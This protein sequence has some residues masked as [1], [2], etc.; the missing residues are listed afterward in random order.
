MRQLKLTINHVL[1][2]DGKETTLEDNPIAGLI[3]TLPI[4]DYV[5]AHTSGAQMF[6][7]EWKAL[8]DDL[9]DHLSK[10]LQL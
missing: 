3:L 9:I 6:L 2:E 5:L 7:E 10:K 8:G 1:V 4:P